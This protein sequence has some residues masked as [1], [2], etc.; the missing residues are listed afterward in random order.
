MSNE[1]PNGDLSMFDDLLSDEGAVYQ[2]D[3]FDDS[4]YASYEDFDSFQNNSSATEVVKDG[5]YK[6]LDTSILDDEVL[7]EN[8]DDH[9]NLNSSIVYDVLKSKGFNPNSIKIEN[10]DGEI[11]EVKFSNL[12][13]EEQLSILSGEHEVDYGYTDSEIE[14]ITFL[15]ENNMSLNDLAQAIRQKTI[16]EL[17]NSEPTY[18]VDDFTDDELFIADFKNKYGSEF[19]DEELL[20]ELEKAKE[21]EELF[22]KKVNKLRNDYKAYEEEE[23]QESEKRK[24]EEEMRIY[25]EYVSN[26][27]NVAKNINDMHDTA[28]LEY[29][30]KEE[31]LDFIFTE[32]NNGKTELQ[33]AFDDPE[34]LFKAAWYIKYGDHVIKEIHKY[35]QSEIAKLSKQSKQNSVET[36]VKNKTQHKTQHTTQQ[37]PKRIEDLY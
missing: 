31:I 8:A 11:E 23:R 24:Q 33:K 12:S 2:N 5:G 3:P 34:T 27:V 25:N 37:R 30:D 10:E 36:V 7:E 19:T 9:T 13:K 18:S 6:S 32:D 35:Y 17:Q 26:M 15:R 22:E 28:E 1:L 16:E 29:S 20:L 4:E 14:A 21:H